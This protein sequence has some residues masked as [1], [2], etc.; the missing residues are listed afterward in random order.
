MAN[1]EKL[2]EN[3]I[4]LKDEKSVLNG[5]IH[6]IRESFGLTKLFIKSELTAEKL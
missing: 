6:E 3:L 5:K 1:V 4:M 2:A